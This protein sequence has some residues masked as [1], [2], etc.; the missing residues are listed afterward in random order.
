MLN[1]IFIKLTVW[2]FNCVLTN[3]WYLMELC[4][5]HSNTYK[6]FNVCKQIELLVL[7]YNNWHHLTG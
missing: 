2:S 1:W 6:H 7:D 3:D 5:I 4:E